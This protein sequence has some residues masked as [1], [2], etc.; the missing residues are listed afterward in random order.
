[1][2]VYHRS[3]FSYYIIT[4]LIRGIL[5]GD[6]I[7]AKSIHK[8]S[9]YWTDGAIARYYSIP[10]WKELCSQYYNIEDILVFGQKSGLIT[11]PAGKIK[12]RILRLIPDSLGRFLTNKCKMG[13][14]LVVKLTK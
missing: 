6:L 10:E 8:T 7:K 2:M 12:D 3:F 11:L 4:G 14:F 9:Q 1:V 5:L 13:E